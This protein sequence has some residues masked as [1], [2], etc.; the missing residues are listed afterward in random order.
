M[1]N[2]ILELVRSRDHVSFAELNRLI[3]GFSGGET[4]LLL[5]GKEN[6]V[7]WANM[8]DD[9]YN[10][11]SELLTGKLVHLSPASFLVYLADGICLTLPIVKQVRNYKRP[12]WAPCVLRPGPA[13]K[14]RTAA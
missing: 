14:Y 11:V 1:K 7:V 3:P 4:S 10:A 5:T 8:T 2:E 9:G 13:P 12:H 6:I